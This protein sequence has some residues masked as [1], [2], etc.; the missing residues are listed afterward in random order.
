MEKHVIQSSCLC[1]DAVTRKRNREPVHTC[2]LKDKV[3]SVDRF[4]KQVSL[5][6]VLKIMR[7]NNA[8]SY[9]SHFWTRNKIC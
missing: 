7:N 9:K 6:Q 2:I 3:L 5:V 4:F 8:L 1:F